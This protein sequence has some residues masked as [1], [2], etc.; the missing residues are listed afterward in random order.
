MDRS[1]E[2][3]G[4]RIGAQGIDQ[5]DGTKRV[6]KGD[7]T[8]GIGPEGVGYGELATGRGSGG[9]QTDEKEA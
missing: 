4:N 1:R 5:R 3:G 6:N 7:G 8:K 9:K 2:A